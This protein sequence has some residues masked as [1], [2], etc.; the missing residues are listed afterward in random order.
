MNNNGSANIVAGVVALREVNG[1]IE[2]L[3]VQEAMPS[4]YGLWSLPSG[5]VN[6]N[7]KTTD[8]ALREAEEESKYKF[9]LLFLMRIYH[10]TQPGNNIIGFFYRAE[11]IGGEILAG[12]TKEIL[13][14]RWFPLAEVRGLSLRSRSLISQVLE[15]IEAKVGFSVDCVKVI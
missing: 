14:A 11:V 4:C 3:M 13:A 8:A 6:P 9:R 12:S 1:V 15:D 7:E 2:L 5:T 10:Q